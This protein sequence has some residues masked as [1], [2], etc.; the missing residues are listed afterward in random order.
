MAASA[1][2]V[3]KLPTNNRYAPHRITNTAGH[4]NRCERRAIP[5]L[6]QLLA[7]PNILAA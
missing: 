4:N 6:F 1:S 3:L 2:E 5:V 7:K